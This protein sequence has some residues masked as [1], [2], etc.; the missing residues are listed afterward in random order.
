MPSLHAHVQA[1]GQIAADHEPYVQEQ[2][3]EFLL[4]VIL[5]GPY[6]SMEHVPMAFVLKSSLA[7]L[8]TGLDDAN[9][10]VKACILDHHDPQDKKRTSSL[11][12]G[13]LCREAAAAS[14]F[15]SVAEECD[16]QDHS[17][18]LTIATT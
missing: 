18:A 17:M 11:D 14:A 8:V 16:T 4:T 7:K 13:Q 2:H 12:C 15:A 6:V 3:H 9:V 10:R 5:V 1:I